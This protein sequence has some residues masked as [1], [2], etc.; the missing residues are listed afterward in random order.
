MATPRHV[1]MRD[2]FD[3][4][5]QQ[6]EWIQTCFDTNRDLFD[7][8]QA[9]KKLMATTAPGF[10]QELN[11]ILMENYILQACKI[12]DPPTT[13][14]GKGET[15]ENLTVSN[16][17]GLLGAQGLMT[18]EIKS[19]SEALHRYREL[20][21]DARNR[22]ISHADKETA[23][24]YIELGWHLKSEALAFLDSMHKYCDAIAEAIGAEPLDFRSSSG[25]GDV[26]DL[27]KALNGGVYL[28]PS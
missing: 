4:F 9:R 8:G 13:R 12:T 1:Q 5:R 22:S 28:P 21:L 20:I 24:S 3:A 14:V 17:N 27:F 23:L 11:I 7:S 16:L 26:A 19:S 10:F 18:D 6:C 15:R 25:P 2:T